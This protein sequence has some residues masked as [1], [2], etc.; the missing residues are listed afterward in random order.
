MDADG[1]HT[2]GVGPILRVDRGSLQP[3]GLRRG[4]VVLG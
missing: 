1:P 4:P 3:S 2:N